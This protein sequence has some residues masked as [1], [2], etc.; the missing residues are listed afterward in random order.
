MQYVLHLHHPPNF[1]SS[2]SIAVVWYQRHCCR[3]PMSCSSSHCLVRNADIPGWSMR[4][5]TCEFFRFIFQAN[6]VLAPI[7][8]CLPPFGHRSQTFLTTCQLQPM[9][10]LRSCCVSCEF[11]VSGSNI[12]HRRDSPCPSCF[13]S[14]FYLIQLPLL[15]IHIS[16]LRYLFAVKV[17]IMPIFGFALCE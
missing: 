7:R 12:R 6:D 4:E 5:C 10:H 1:V 11:C 3:R 17:V 8:R 15:W 2:S 9:S 14:I 16:K 13:L